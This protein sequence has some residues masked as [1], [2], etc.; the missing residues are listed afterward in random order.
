MKLIKIKLYIYQLIY[1]QIKH[2]KLMTQNMR[3]PGNGFLGNIAK[4]LMIVFNEFVY[5]DSIKKL[6]VKKNDNVIEIGSGNGQ[7]IKKL[8]S[9]TSKNIISIE[10]SNTFRNKLIKKYKNQNVTILSN[11]AKNLS[12]IVKDNS[13]DKLLAVNVVYFLHPIIDYAREFF[14]ILKINGLGV[15]V[16]KFEGIKN[17]DNK[18]APNKNLE[19]IVNAFEKAGF[20]VKTEF[21][22]SNNTQ[23]EYHAI[24]LSKSKNEP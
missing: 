16:C 8:L 3:S 18:V 14:R 13:F 21:I 6:N 11:D 1:S 12:D 22:K 19:D 17:F 10:V 5:N 9:L 20:R 15:L 23:K 24:Y 4:E 2:T 7:G